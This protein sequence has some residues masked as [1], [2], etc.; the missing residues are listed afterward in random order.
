MYMLLLAII[1]IAFI[2]LGLPDSLLGAGWPSMYGDLSVPISFVGG[3]T[4]ITTASTIVSSLLSER[5]T[6]YFGIGKVVV[7]SVFLTAIA[8]FVYSITKNYYI[9]LV[10]AIPYGF[11]A[12][13]VDA[14]INNYVS[15]HYSSKHMS[16]LHA[17]WGIGASVS[18]FIMS[19]ALLN[20]DG[21]QSGYQI[22]AIIQFVLVIILLFT[23]KL[24]GKQNAEN[25]AEE[26]EKTQPLS[27]KEAV[28][29]RGVKFVLIAFLCYSALECVSGVWA[30]SWLVYHLGLEAAFAAKFASFI[31]IGITAG[32]I[33]CGFIA[34]KFGDKLLIRGGT[35]VVFVGLLLIITEISTEIAMVGLIIMGFGC[36][37]IFPSIIHQ[38]PYYFGRRNS[39]AIIGIQMAFAYTGN[40]IMPPLFGLVAERVGFGFYGYFLMFLAVMMFLMCERLNKFMKINKSH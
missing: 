16:W 10:F 1:Y 7:G 27:F 35:A 20:F 11:G 31:F 25:F 30:T 13:G 38:T 17:F 12:G 4:M 15:V 18:P 19:Y 22:V 24:W 29:V 21:W 33:F 40:T 28:S 5:M 6:K 2:S 34:D 32:R 8:M 9:L 26:E 37:P 23:I 3:I 39:Q 36:A 14:S